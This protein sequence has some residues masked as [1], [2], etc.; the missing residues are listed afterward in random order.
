MEVRRMQWHALFFLY[1]ESVNLK[2]SHGLV[3]LSPFAVVVATA[4]E[5]TL[6]K[7]SSKASAAG[8]K[9]G[10]TLKPSSRDTQRRSGD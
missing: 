10:F 6:S 2:Q 9:G 3:T 8:K 4:S 1:E 7:R 5:Q